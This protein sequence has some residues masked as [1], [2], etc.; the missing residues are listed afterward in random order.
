M[1][2]EPTKT[3]FHKI[4]LNLQQDLETGMNICNKKKKPNHPKLH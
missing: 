4:V 2:L 1:N 3:V